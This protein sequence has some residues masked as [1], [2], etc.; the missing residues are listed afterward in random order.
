[1]TEGPGLDLGRPRDAR[2]L[3]RDAIVIYGR[4]FGLLLLLSLAVVAPIQLVVS[5]VGLEEL[6]SA[7]RTD[8]PIERTVIPTL[9]SFLVATPL[10]TAAT[11]FVLGSLAAGERPRAGRTLQ[12]ALDVF[13]PVFAAVALAA[14]GIALGL[15]ALVI[16]GVYVAV[17]WYFVTQAVAIDGARS[18]KALARSWDIVQDAF[19]RTFLIV[20]AANVAATAPAI[21]ILTPFTALAETADRE[22]VLLVAEILTEGLTTPFVALVSTL[23]FYDLKLRKE[24]VPEVG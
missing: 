1:M 20:L 12:A 17:R 6:T 13:A 22:A 24:S 10:I 8:S 21:L 3:F 14:V 4:N 5:G 9:V 16:P 7:Y 19:W 2:A 15:L 23:L 11:I 18:T